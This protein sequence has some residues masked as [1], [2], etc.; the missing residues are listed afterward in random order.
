[1]RVRITN[2]S[3]DSTGT[4]YEVDSID[5]LVI[6]MMPALRLWASNKMQEGLYD[7]IKRDFDKL[8]GEM[9]IDLKLSIEIKTGE[10]NG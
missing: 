1:M 6:E 3:Y 10:T 4:V 8:V 2:D 5:D 7:G 9:V